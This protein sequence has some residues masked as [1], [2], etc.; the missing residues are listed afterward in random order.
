MD[1]TGPDHVSN[2][3][4]AVPSYLQLLLRLLALLVVAATT[5]ANAQPYPNRPITF[6]V[7]FAPGGL[8]DVPAR[9]LAALMQEKI[10]QSIVVENRPGASG[11]TGATS[12]LRAEPDGYTILV[13][14]L[15]DVQ[16]LHYLS[17]PY[18][19][20]KDFALIGMVVDGPPLVL[21]VNPALPYRSVADLV[22]DARANPTKVSFGTSG[23]AT[24]PA[25][26]VTQVNS[27]AKTSIVGVPYR[28]SAA[29]AAGVVTGEVQGAFVFYTNAKPL[30]ED[31]KV[32]AL[33]VATPQR[34]AGWPEIPTMAELG[35]A[36]VDHR[37]FVGLAAP[38]NTPASIVAFL[39]KHLNE[40]IHSAAFR[41]RMEPLGMTIPDDN[42]PERFAE[43]MRRE[44]AKQAEL[45]RLSGHSPLAPQR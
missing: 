39:N 10:G 31:G 4:D 41:Q 1:C 38:R 25:I 34:L 43:F 2:M 28:G 14:A 26:A 32:R 24:S 13:N 7:P 33:A 37:G 22:A 6:V 29:A 18:D 45:A 40:A 16:N 19:P 30:S 42:T 11:V 23:P 5:S 44:N 21:V 27:L 15:A 8:S 12:V 36:G 9:A 3:R 20:I 17:V 35:F